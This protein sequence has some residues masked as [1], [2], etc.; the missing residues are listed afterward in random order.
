MSAIS[1]ERRA[2]IGTDDPV[3]KAPWEAQAFAM[4]IALYEQGTFTWPEWAETLAAAIAD[5]AEAGD[6]YYEQWMT[7]LER[8]CMAR[9][10]ASRQ[11]LDD[12]AAAWER[13]A[14]ATPHGQP[15]VLENDPFGHPT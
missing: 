14:E 1:P 9:G 2:I 5:T 4:T 6:S 13:A 12:R 7:A 15:I 10:L 3:F 8:L 11:A